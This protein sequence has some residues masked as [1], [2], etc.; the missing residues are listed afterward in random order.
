MLVMASFPLRDAQKNT[1][2]ELFFRE[3]AGSRKSLA[4]ENSRSK[5]RRSL[6]GSR[7]ESAPAWP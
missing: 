6:S 5:V 7:S 2:A 3:P 4:Q 1:H